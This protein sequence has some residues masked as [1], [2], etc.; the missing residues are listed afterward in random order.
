M[1]ENAALLLIAFTLFTPGYWLNQW[2]DPYV[3][4]DAKE[5]VQMADVAEDGASLRVRLAGEDFSSGKEVETTVA[6]L[7][8]PK[9]DGD[10]A[11]RLLKNSGIEFRT[12]DDGK[13]YVDN[14]AF[15]QYAQKKGVDFDWQVLRVEE[16]ADRMPKEIFYIPALLL[17][18]LVAW[19]QLGRVRKLEQKPA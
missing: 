3:F 19:L 4:V 16:D 13:T 9:S 15:G 6:L 12:E 14:V 10:G 11:A 18:A 2:K 7:L 1:W 17:L 8:G 5:L